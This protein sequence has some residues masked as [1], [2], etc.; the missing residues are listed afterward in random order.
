[1]RVCDI[2]KINNATYDK[3]AVVKDD[4]TSKDLE[5]CCR[6]YRELRHREELHRYKAYEETVKTATGE[7]PLK[8]HWW[9]MFGW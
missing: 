6:C 2:C 5:L 8:S 4:G 1:M 3:H 7:L 9:N